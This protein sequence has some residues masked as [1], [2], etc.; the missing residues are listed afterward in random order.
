MFIQNLITFCSKCA[1]LDCLLNRYKTVFCCCYYFAIFVTF[2]EIEQ[3]L[4]QF[5][6]INILLWQFMVEYYTFYYVFGVRDET[7]MKT[8]ELHSQLLTWLFLT[9]EKGAHDGLLCLFIFIYFLC[10]EFAFNR[11]SNIYHRSKWVFN[12]ISHGDFLTPFGINVN[13]MFIFMSNFGVP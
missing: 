13:Q 2:C 1:G 10:E 7:G 4:R 6:A 8:I 9:H 5:V 12:G 11:F 3:Y